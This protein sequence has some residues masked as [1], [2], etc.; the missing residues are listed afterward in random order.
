MQEISVTDR[1]KFDLFLDI[2]NFG[3]LIN[4][5]W[6]RVDSYTAPSNV[7]PAIVNL[8]AQGGTTTYSYSPNASYAG[9][10]DTIVSKPAIARIAS[11]YRVQ[12]GIRFRF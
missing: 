1:A 6:G 2:E 10:A 5:D 7:A 9:T 3:N 12:F 8:I 11:A 4:S